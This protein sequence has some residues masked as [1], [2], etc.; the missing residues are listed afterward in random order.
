MIPKRLLVTHVSE[1]TLEPK[2]KY[3]LKLMR[4]MHPGWEF[5][6]FPDGDCRDLWSGSFRSSPSSMIGIRAR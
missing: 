3:C 6:F 4:E 1:H 2:L 5:L